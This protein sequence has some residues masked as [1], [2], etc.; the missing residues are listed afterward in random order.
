VGVEVG[1]FDAISNMIEL[2]Y[3]LTKKQFYTHLVAEQ[4][5]WGA[6]LLSGSRPDTG[7]IVEI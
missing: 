7:C 5:D 1:I 4:G 2:Y 3:L 6:A